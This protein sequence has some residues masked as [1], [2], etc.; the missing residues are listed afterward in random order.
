MLVAKFELA[1]V[2]V[3]CNLEMNKSDYE[4]YK[5]ENELSM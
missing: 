2:I 1:F 4:N 5:N 3:G